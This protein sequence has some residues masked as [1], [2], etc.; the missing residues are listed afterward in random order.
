MPED[1]SLERYRIASAIS[2]ERGATEWDAVDS[3]SQSAL[4]IGSLIHMKTEHRRVSNPWANAIDSDAV[5]C[6]IQRQC[7]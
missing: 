4:R 2:P 1:S 5:F 7:F 6:Q 3:L